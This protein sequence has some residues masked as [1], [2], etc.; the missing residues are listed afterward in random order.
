MY[1]STTAATIDPLTS[2]RVMVYP[3]PKRAISLRV[4][5]D[6][7]EWFKAGGPR[8]Q[9]RMNSVLRSYMSAT[10]GGESSVR[11]VSEPR[12]GAKKKGV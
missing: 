4:D 7:L 2:L 10:R 6:V 8:Y 12:R 1:D 3:E 9:S 11:T 5:E